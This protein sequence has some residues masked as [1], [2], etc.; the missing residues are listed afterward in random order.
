LIIEGESEK[1]YRQYLYID[2]KIELRPAEMAGLGVYVAAKLFCER[3]GD[4]V[5]QILIGPGGE[6]GY[7][8]ASI[9]NTD[10]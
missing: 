5:S 2:K 9:T 6:R 3:Y 10:A 8:A 4:K 1:D 7:S